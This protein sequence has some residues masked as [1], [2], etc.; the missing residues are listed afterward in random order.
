MLEVIAGL[1][2]LTS[3]GGQVRVFNCH[4]GPFSTPGVTLAVFNGYVL[5]DSCSGLGS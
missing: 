5:G 2:N 1:W 3:L 4:L